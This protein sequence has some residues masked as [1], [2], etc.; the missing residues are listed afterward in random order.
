MDARTRFEALSPAFLEVTLPRASNFDAV[1][2]L[3]QG[4]PEEIA[5]TPGRRN[6]FF[7]EYLMS[8]SIHQLTEI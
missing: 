6:L 4:N 3:R 5:R 8:M 2:L 1:A 7:G